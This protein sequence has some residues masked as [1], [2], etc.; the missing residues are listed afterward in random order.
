MKLIG[1]VLLGHGVGGRTDL[2]VPTWLVGYSA[3]AVL[4]ISFVA[5]AAFWRT[6]RLEGSPWPAGPYVVRQPIVVR[7]FAGVLRAI[8]VG[9]FALVVA[10]A[11]FGV[12]DPVDNL[13]P[14][15]IY[16][17]FWVGVTLVNGLVGDA[18]RFLDPFDTF[19]R[20]TGADE[21]RPYRPGYWPAAAGLFVFVWLE[22]VY[23]DGARPIVL[24]VASLV[25]TVVMLAGIV[26]FGRPVVHYGNP[27]RAWF[28]LLGAMAPIGDD[29]RGHARLRWPATGLA[30]IA[31][32]RGTIA[33]VM[34][35]LGST[36]FDGVTR[37]TAWSDLT[38][39][40]DDPASTVVATLGLALCI[41]VVSVV[42]LAAMRGA[43]LLTKER[44]GGT[45]VLANA[46]VHSLVPIAFAYAVAHYLSLLLF[47][48]QAFFA[49]I[50]DPFGNGSDYFDSA[51]NRI[52]F[53]AVA[54]RTISYLQV[55]AITLG[56]VAGV[57]LAHDRA[58]ALF[59]KREATRSQYPLLVVMVLFT[60]V[61]LLLLLG[62]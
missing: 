38:G 35:A 39:P 14:T 1:P 18:F 31:P 60:V 59:D 24:G 61:G 7:S 11:L 56:H 26:R 58:L 27:F 10:A 17:T 36:A 3:G 28:D 5:L 20:V 51:D 47:E 55:A 30:G 52:N 21:G 45:V 2:P 32:E 49:L 12:D 23:E 16:V 44:A 62:G 22:L 9:L 25:L 34:V 57:V 42:Y 37:T 41:V 13:A 54:P 4:V 40:L 43:A 50:S 48:G 8:G 29:G 46:F 53:T 19:A 15:A 6:P 33:V